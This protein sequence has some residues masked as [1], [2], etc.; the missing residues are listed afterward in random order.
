[1]DGTSS[2]GV[3]T[4][5][6]KDARYL[7]AATKAFN[8][9]SRHKTVAC[10]SCHGERG[11]T[12]KPGIPS[13][14]GLAPQYLVD[15]MKEYANGKRTH[16]VMNAL[17]AGVSESEFKDI[18]QFYARQVPARASTPTLGDA[19][20]AKNLSAACAGCHGP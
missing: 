16:A 9:P 6:G 3:P 2:V 7:S 14:A 10:A 11:V 15:E 4:L 1:D 12:S 13:L 18:A 20:A 19:A 5:A 8:N 17:L